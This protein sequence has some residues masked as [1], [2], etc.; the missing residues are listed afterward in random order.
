VALHDFVPIRERKPMIG[1]IS[2][3]SIRSGSVIIPDIA[4][5]PQEGRIVALWRARRDGYAHADW[6]EAHIENGVEYLI[7]KRSDVLGLW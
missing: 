3:R 6:A 5:G 4:R 1:I 2:A 7:M